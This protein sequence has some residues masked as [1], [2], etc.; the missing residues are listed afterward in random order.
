MVAYF[1]EIKKL[2]QEIGSS[3]I[4]ISAIRNRLRMNGGFDEATLEAA[5]KY[6]EDANVLIKVADTIIMV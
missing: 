3:T 5:I 2:A 6:Y 4:E 1:T